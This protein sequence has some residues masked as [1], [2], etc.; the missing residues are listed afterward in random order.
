MGSG[1]VIDGVPLAVPGIEVVNYLDDPKLKLSL[2][3]GKP[4]TRDDVTLIVLHST[5][6]APD[7]TYTHPQTVIPGRGPSTNAGER[8]NEMW[9]HDGRCAGAHEVV[10]NDGVTYQLC[11]LH[12]WESY[13][14]TSVNARAIGVEFRQGV[15]MSEFYAEAFHAGRVGVD[16]KTAYFGIQRMIPKGYRNRA[17]K[18]L[19]DG[20]ADF[21][22]VIGHRDQSDNRGAGDPGDALMAEFATAGYEQFDVDLGE[23]RDVWRARQRWLGMPASQQDGVPGPTTRSYLKGLGF[24]C[25]LWA[26][27]PKNVSIPAALRPPA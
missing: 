7:R 23:D 17:S 9:Q 18:R 2:Q 15:A 27:R 4:R 21:I 3:D 10:D 6:G 16:W 12:L 8:T 14:A 25:G 20:A 1:F 19:A 11:D 5:L 22:G 13:N 24:T 26:L